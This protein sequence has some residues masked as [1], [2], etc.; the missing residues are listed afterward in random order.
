M[1]KLFAYIFFLML[2]CAA[3]AQLLPVRDF[4]TVR[5]IEKHAC[6]LNSEIHSSFKPYYFN[7]AALHEEPAYKRD[8][9]I[10][11]S[12]SYPPK[13]IIALNVLP[14]YDAFYGID[15]SDAGNN[16]YLLNAG[17]LIDLTIYEKIGISYMG[18]YSLF[19]LP[20]YMTTNCLGTYVLNGYNKIFGE[21][22]HYSYNN[23][24]IITYLP[25]DFLKLEL[26]NSKNFYGDGYRSFLLSDNAKNYPY[27]KIETQFLNIKY[28]CIWA[29]QNYFETTSDLTGTAVKNKFSVFHY[30]DWKI[31]KHFSLGLFEA[32]LTKNE[33]FFDFEY[34]NPVIFFRPVEYSLGSEGNALLGINLKYSFKPLASVYFQAVLDDVIVKQLINDV[35]HAVNKNY[36]GEYGWF[37]NKWALQLG[38]KS[39]DI[40]RI[41]NLDFFTEINVARPYTYSH[42]YSEQNYSHYGQPLAHP[43]GANFVESVTG[44]NYFRNK[45]NINIKFMYA[46]A[47]M[48]TDSTTHYGQN[49][50]LPTMDGVQSG[51]QYQVQSYYNT[52]LQGN[53]TKIISSRVEFSYF[54]KENRNIALNCGIMLRSVNTQAGKNKFS[55]FFYAGIRTSVS[56]VTE[57]MF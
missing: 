37:A 13:S 46:A 19:N 1:N 20:D 47:G 6:G 16:P 12:P 33:K 40:F 35:K 24:V 38:I 30:L 15:F 55:G 28:S 29:M 52:I 50:F 14:V 4:R 39:F 21:K 27:F 43:L 32:I 9:Q 57:K 45:F 42:V 44:I 22:Y 11:T 53:K 36:T 26:A 41:E 7:E 54:I 8:L 18:T 25:F 31:G 48:D 17:A 5:N 34:L 23:D 2:S 51:W 56:N 3:T 10:N 49:I